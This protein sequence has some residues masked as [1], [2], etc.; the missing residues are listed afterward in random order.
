MDLA[1]LF[2]SYMS[3]F[4][5]S[6]SA[7]GPIRDSSGTTYGPAMTRLT[8]TPL[9][10]TDNPRAFQTPGAIG[11]YNPNSKSIMVN[12]TINDP[13]ETIRHE[14][15]H[16]LLGRMPQQQQSD[17]AVGAPNYG[18][19]ANTLSKQVAGQMYQEVPAYM[20]S[21]P[22]SKFLGVS[23]KDRD[24]Y[25][26]HTRDVLM[27]LHPEIGAHFQRLLDSGNRPMPTGGAANFNNYSGQ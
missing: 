21:S 23:Q 26:Q 9:S 10:F 19:I 15:I 25:L 1:S 20:G 17:V 7:G 6:P 5:R 24:D 18:A 8:R 11:E 14:S 3:N 13:G 12:P 22:T 2:S 27:Q 16:A 4:G